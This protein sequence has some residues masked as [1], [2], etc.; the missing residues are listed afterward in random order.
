[1]PAQRDSFCVVPLADLFNFNVLDKSTAVR[2]LFVFRRPDSNSFR[3]KPFKRI[4]KRFQALSVDNDGL[5]LKLDLENVM[6]SIA[7]KFRMLEIAVREKMNFTDCLHSLAL[8]ARRGAPAGQI[9]LPCVCR[10]VIRGVCRCFHKSIFS[11]GIC[12]NSERRRWINP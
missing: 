7:A 2:N 4:A 3:C 8:R 6:V 9:F 5:I 10:D 1:M 12:F 11:V